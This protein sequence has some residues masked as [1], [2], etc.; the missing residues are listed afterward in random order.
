MTTNP[1]GACLAQTERFLRGWIR[2]GRGL[3]NR[4]SGGS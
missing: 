4:L 1:V 2:A 3:Q